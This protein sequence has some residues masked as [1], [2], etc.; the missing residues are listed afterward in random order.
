M[1]ETYY[2]PSNERGKGRSSS[3]K[4]YD[5]YTNLNKELRKVNLRKSNF[6]QSSQSSS[7]ELYITAS[8]PTV[9]EAGNECKI[10][11]LCG[12]NKVMPCLKIFFSLL[13]DLKLKRSLQFLKIQLEPWEEVKECWEYTTSFRLSQLHNERNKDLKVADYIN[14]YPILKQPGGHLLVCY[15]FHVIKYALFSKNYFYLYFTCIF[16][17]A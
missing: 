1:Q 5:A 12:F 10:N 11:S 6:G 7:S 3:G 4:L 13:D 9:A 8:I 16:S 14:K 15:F 2:I 17:T